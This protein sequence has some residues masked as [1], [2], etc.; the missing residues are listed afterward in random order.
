MGSLQ[1]ARLF[2]LLR[3]HFINFPTSVA[4]IIPEDGVRCRPSEGNIV[5]VTAE[6][7][8]PLPARFNFFFF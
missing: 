3:D 4:V 6:S 8:K 7:H 2:L 5:L 1:G